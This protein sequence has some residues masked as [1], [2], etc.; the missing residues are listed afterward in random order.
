[1][2][3]VV[4]VTSIGCVLGL[5]LAAATASLLSYVGIHFVYAVK[6]DGRHKSRA[7]AGGHLTETRECILRSGFSQGSASHCLPFQM[8]GL[9]LWQTDIWNAYLEAK[10]KERVYVSLH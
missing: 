2:M 5:P 4:W 3:C 7:V 9:E 1:M 6:H 10:T 8:N